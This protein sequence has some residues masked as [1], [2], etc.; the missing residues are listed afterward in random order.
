M[1]T[2]EMDSIVTLPF[3]FAKREVRHI[4]RF[5]QSRIKSGFAQKLAVVIL[6]YPMRCR[7]FWFVNT[8][9]SVCRV[10]ILGNRNN[11]LLSLSLGQ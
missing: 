11:Y 8:I 1:P 10:K 6:A 4:L 5:D 9:E 7:V 3:L 2:D